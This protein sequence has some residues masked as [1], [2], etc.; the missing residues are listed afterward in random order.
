MGSRSSIP[1]GMALRPSP[2]RTQSAV[3]CT[4]CICESRRIYSRRRSSAPSSGKH[5]TDRQTY[6][7][8]W[9]HAYPV[10]TQGV[11]M[12]ETAIERLAEQCCDEFHGEGGTFQDFVDDRARWREFARY[13]WALGARP[14]GIHSDENAAEALAHEAFLAGHARPVANDVVNDAF[15]RWW[16]DRQNRSPKQ[17]QW[18]LTGQAWV[19]L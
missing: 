19:D 10:D 18:V 8:W 4:T 16:A 9:I 2:A 12:S 14:Q 7:L 6:R 5:R 11:R 17:P 3:K 1:S 15:G 13:L